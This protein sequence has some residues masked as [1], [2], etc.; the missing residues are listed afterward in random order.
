MDCDSCVQSITKAV[1]RLDPKAHVAADLATKRV[2]IGSDGQP[3]D[4]I[5]AIEAAG[6]IV[7]AAA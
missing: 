5:A 6:F 7:N 4:F 1:H 2:V 3:H